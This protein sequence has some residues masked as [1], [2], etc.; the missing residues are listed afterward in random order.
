MRFFTSRCFFFL[1]NNV[2]QNLIFV[3]FCNFQPPNLKD[4]PSTVEHILFARV[5]FEFIVVEKS[6]PN[7]THFTGEGV[8]K[9][10]T[11]F[12][13]KNG[14]IV[15]LPFFSRTTQRVKSNSLC[16][17]NGMEVCIFFFFLVKEWALRI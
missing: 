13:S 16:L 5:P 17:V 14:S 4:L 9:M 6:V 1:P 11:V 7:T 2:L 3:A 12:F 8:Q 10:Y 15:S